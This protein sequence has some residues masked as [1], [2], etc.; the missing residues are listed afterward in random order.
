[1]Q[2][3]ADRPAPDDDYAAMGLAH[4]DE[5]DL[6]AAIDEDNDDAIAD[7]IARHEL[8]LATDAYDHMYPGAG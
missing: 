5:G 1:M 2:T 8:A 7:A 3:P 4:T 6:L